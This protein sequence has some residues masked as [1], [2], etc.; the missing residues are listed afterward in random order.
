MSIEF[1]LPE[2]GEN[3]ESGDVVNVLV[4]EGQEIEGNHSVVELE[5]DKAVVEIP[6]PFAGRIVKIHVKKGDKVKVGQAIVT[7]ESDGEAQ[8]AAAGKV[9]ETKAAEAK[10]P[11]AGE[12]ARPAQR[13]VPPAAPEDIPAGPAARRVAREKGI[14][15]RSVQG[16]GSRGRITPEDVR[17]AAAPP[18]ARPAVPAAPAAASAAAGGVSTVSSME[19]VIPPGEPS[20]DDWGGG[21]PGADVEDP[22]DDR[23]T[24]GA[25]GQHHPACD[26]LRRRRHY[27]VG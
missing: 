25:F 26:E 18:A 3:I 11:E 4:T 14:D 15:L 8:P 19:P 20:Q 10:A 17:A 6:C 1:K 2:L 24:D 16:S 21:A 5:T 13:Q 12:A 23:R 22:Q 9:A 27:G 7:V